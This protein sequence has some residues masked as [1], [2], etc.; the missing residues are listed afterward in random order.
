MQDI[1]PKPLLDNVEPIRTPFAEVIHGP[2]GQSV[3]RVDA[4]A[5]IHGK[6]K[7]GGDLIPLT[8][9]LHVGVVRSKFAHAEILNI[10]TDEARQITGIVGVYTAKDVRGTNRVGLI[11]R[12]H[13]V[14][15]S[16][17]VMYLGDA[18]ALVVGISERAVSL[19]K[20]RVKVGYN[21]L[22]VVGSLSEALAPGAPELRPGG[23]VMGGKR[24]HRGDAAREFANPDNIIVEETFQTQTVDHAFLDLEAG[25]AI[26]N[27]QLLT[28]HAS[29]QWTHEDRRLVALA[30]GLPLEQVRIQCPVTGGAFGGREDISIQAMLAVVALNHPNKLVALKY[31]REESMIVRHKRHPIQFQYRLAA[32][33]A[34]QIVAAQIKIYSEEGAYASTGP[35]VLRKAASHCTGPYLVPNISCDVYGVYTNNNPKGAMRGFGAVQMAVAYEGMIDRLA[36]R[37]NVDRLEVR[38]RNLIRHGDPVTTGQRIANASVRECLDAAVQ[39]F[40][41]TKGKEVRPLLPHERRGIGYSSICFGLG[42]GDG[43]P[44]ASRARVT[45]QPDRV[46]VYTG[47][48]DYGQGITTVAA[49]IAAEVLGLSVRDIEVVT[50]DTQRTPEAG[51][52]SASRQTYFSGSAIRL[53]ASELRAELLD[54]ASHIHR[55]HPVELQLLEGHLVGRFDAKIKMP[56]KDLV[57]QGKRRGFK[58]EGTAV[59]ESNTVCE[60]FSN[61]QSPLAFATYL[62]GAHVCQVHVDIETGVVTVERFVACHDVGRAINPQSV[63]GQ[64]SGGVAQGIGM[65]LMEEVVMDAGAMRSINF[66]DYL[67]P[68]TRDVPAIEAVIVESHDPT[69]PFGAHGVGEPPVVAS[70]PAILSAISDAIGKFVNTTP[71]TPEKVWKRVNER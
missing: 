23:N 6:A 24:L 21:P 56:F 30:V 60:D 7:Y 14:L 2:V 18:V 40:Q 10:D 39:R 9:D 26:F 54:V 15:A 11:F 20:H 61:G 52:T 34:G 64:I 47:A 5:K 32:T 13:P 17:N 27:G 12:D 57:L 3:P 49:Q 43:F 38:R 70:V 29:G 67:L 1:S 69:G 51:S 41:S 4:L 19:A 66:R 58:L 53:A 25:V 63:A 55:V 22:P 68:T 44:D 36:A 71:C 28:I 59:F 62:F 65:A 50:A 42:Y 37:L 8:A 46:C 35:A 33:P 16:E 45:A 31:D 48:V